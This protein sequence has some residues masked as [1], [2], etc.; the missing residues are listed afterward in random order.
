MET[1]NVLKA[2]VLSTTGDLVLVKKSAFKAKLNCENLFYRVV[3][4]E[5]TKQMEYIQMIIC[6]CFN[7]LVFLNMLICF[8]FNLFYCTTFSD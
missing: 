8:I 5:K 2:V 3:N 4:D 6:S 1:G 7:V